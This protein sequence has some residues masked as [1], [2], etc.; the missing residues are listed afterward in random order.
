MVRQ[1]GLSNM[2]LTCGMRVHPQEQVGVSCVGAYSGGTA[3]WQLFMVT[4]AKHE[5]CHKPT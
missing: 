1:G 5:P 3:E 2:T 4:R